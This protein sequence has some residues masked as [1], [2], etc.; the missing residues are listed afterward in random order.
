MNY[1]S[2]LKYSEIEGI[3]SSSLFTKLKIYHASLTYWTSILL[4]IP[5]MFFLPHV[6][7]KNFIECIYPSSFCSLLIKKKNT[8]ACSTISLHWFLCLERK[9]DYLNP[10]KTCKGTGLLS[11]L[12]VKT[13]QECESARMTG[14]LPHT[15]TALCLSSTNPHHH[16]HPPPATSDRP[17]HP[18]PATRR[19]LGIPAV[20][21]ELPPLLSVFFSSR[22]ESWTSLG[23]S[24]ASRGGRLYGSDC[25]LEIGIWGAYINFSL[26]FKFKVN[27]I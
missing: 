12:F 22:S 1:N 14:S 7:S 15:W 3:H 2:V 24:H 17:F 9:Q 5:R 19:D 16:L 26:R 8:E 13:L 27:V 20:T 23:P 10:G 18:L 6:I 25:F 4:H 21:Q 11:L